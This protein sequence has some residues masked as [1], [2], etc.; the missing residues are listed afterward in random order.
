MNIFAGVKHGQSVLGM[1]SRNLEFIARENRSFG[2]HIADN[3]L[4]AKRA[5]EDAGI[6]IPQTY[7]VITSMRD[8]RSLHPDETPK[9]FVLKP[10]RGFGGS[11]ILVAYTRR[12]NG[13]WLDNDLREIFWE[14][15]QTH[16]QDILD[17]RFGAV[18]IP[19]VAFFE[20]RLSAERMFKPFAYRGVP[21][22][23]IIVYNR[24]PIMAMLRL[25]THESHGRANL[26][27]G[28]IGVGIDIAEG[29]TTYAI[30][31]G[32]VLAGAGSFFSNITIPG[33]SEMLSLAVRASIATHLGFA[34]VDIVA[35]K[36]RGAVVL[37]V[38]ARPGLSIQLANLAGLKERLMRVSGLQVDSPERG[39]HLS[40][41]VFGDEAR[42]TPL[43][44][45][46]GMR[47][48]RATEVVIL[49]HKDDSGKSVSVKAKIDSGARSSSIDYDLAEAIGYGGVVSYIKPFNL[50]ASMD[51][52]RAH[53]VARRIKKDIQSHP[54]I[55][56]LKVVLSATGVTLRVTVPLSFE[57]KGKIIE[58]D[59]N[60]IS[61]GHLTY[62][63]IIG[64]RDLSGFLIKPRK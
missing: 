19:D 5:L 40:K 23:R 32:S 54:G 58:T 1:N 9:S 50:D 6:P 39:I 45:I 27:L 60:L 18:D 10:N 63:M 34:G 51:E 15:I 30:Q 53:E 46:G 37:E 31:R 35:S 12:E 47:I 36:R 29:V 17:G 62:D 25:P 61:R 64:R 44:T 41:S 28:G 52:E 16:V 13:A 57:L 24:V 21:D 20:E 7:H 14:D 2:K 22:I 26:H 49:K 48:V 38:N 11:G 55:K 43:S 8:M 3:K 33:W 56:R 42:A 59:V 4:I